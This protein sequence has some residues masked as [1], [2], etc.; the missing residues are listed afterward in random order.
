MRSA[1]TAKRAN[2]R[3]SALPPRDGTARPL[4]L[5]RLSHRL[6]HGIRIPGTGTRHARYEQHLPG[7]RDVRSIGVCAARLRFFFGGWLCE[8]SAES[9]I[10]EGAFG[11]AD[12]RFMLS[13]RVHTSRRASSLTATTPRT[14]LRLLQ[15]S[16]KFGPF[17][18]QTRHVLLELACT[19][20]PCGRSWSHCCPQIRDVVWWRQRVWMYAAAS[21]VDGPA[22]DCSG[23]LCASRCS[24]C[25]RAH[26]PAACNAAST[27]RRTTAMWKRRGTG[28]AIHK[29]KERAGTVT[30]ARTS[31]ASF[32]S[33]A[34][35]AELHLCQAL[36]SWQT[37]LSTRYH[38][39][40]DWSGHSPGSRDTFDARMVQRRP[41]TQCTQPGHDQAV[42]THRGPAGSGSSDGL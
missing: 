8:A 34:A 20:M 4:L 41:S 26:Q 22:M 33:F 27:R 35:F 12:R 42:S 14:E 39:C 16:L 7:R 19:G 15:L 10:A 3:E 17:I 11:G 6:R 25:E 29:R 40:E 13:K 24:A 37:M 2:G 31:L 32:A 5:L 38:G 28:R 1:V 9:G 30:W 23:G 36:S 18:P 21:E